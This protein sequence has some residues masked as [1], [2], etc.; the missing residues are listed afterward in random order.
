MYH[1]V[2]PIFSVVLGSVRHGMGP[3]ALFMDGSIVP[4]VLVGVIS[5]GAKGDRG[6]WHHWEWCLRGLL[7]YF[8][9][10]NLEGLGLGFLVGR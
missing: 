1:P 9:Y 5:A 4:V 10:I 2:V 8:R 3:E 6:K 7:V